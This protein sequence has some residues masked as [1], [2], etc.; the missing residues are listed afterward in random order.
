MYAIRSY[1]EQVGPE[2]A[3]AK[4]TKVAGRLLV[5]RRQGRQPID[6][7]ETG[8]VGPPFHLDG[9]IILEIVVIGPEGDR[10]VEGAD[11]AGVH[12]PAIEACGFV[13]PVDEAERASRNRAFALVG[14]RLGHRDQVILVDLELD[15]EVSYNFV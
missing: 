15:R 14:K 5:D 10:A 1:Y 3:T 6:I 9:A 8:P 7:R 12:V 4:R 2:Q 11:W 13:G